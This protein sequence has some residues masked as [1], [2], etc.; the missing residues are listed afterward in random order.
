MRDFHFSRGRI[1]KCDYFGNSALH[2]AV[3]SRDLKCLS[4][5]L[6]YEPRLIWMMDINNVTA[7]ELSDQLDYE[8]VSRVLDEFYGK[9]MKMKSSRLHKFQ[10]KEMSEAQ[11]RRE[12][13][14]KLMKNANKAMLDEYKR[15]KLHRFEFGSRTY[16]A[17]DKIVIDENITLTSALTKSCKQLS[18][19]SST[20]TSNLITFY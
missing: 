14:E 11:K 8:E 4:F 20:S 3:R 19:A 7:R 16:L 5:L 6:N 1:D 10:M 17:F 12:K 13:Y 2:Y 9:Q 15:K 18:K